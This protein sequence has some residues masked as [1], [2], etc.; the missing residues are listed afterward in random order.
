MRKDISPRSFYWRHRGST[1][2][3]AIPEW[4]QAR[5]QVRHPRPL[6]AC[7]PFLRGEQT[8]RARNLGS[9]VHPC[10]VTKGRAKPLLPEP[11]GRRLG[12]LHSLPIPWEALSPSAKRPHSLTP[13]HHRVRA[14]EPSRPLLRQI[15]HGP[16]GNR[17]SPPRKRK[18]GTLQTPA[19]CLQ[20]LWRLRSWKRST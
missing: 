15:S 4:H 5:H 3:A 10:W 6:L 20:Q 2:F 7:L 1:R 19:P 14:S 11:S 8:R 16:S 12:N 9:M 18:L 13:A 17:D